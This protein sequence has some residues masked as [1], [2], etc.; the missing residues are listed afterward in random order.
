MKMQLKSVLKSNF[1]KLRC[2][3]ESQVVYVTGNSLCIT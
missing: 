3:D 1:T 2:L